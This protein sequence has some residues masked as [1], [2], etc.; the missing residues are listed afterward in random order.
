MGTSTAFVDPACSGGESDLDLQSTKDCVLLRR[1]VAGDQL[2]FAEVVRRH[3]SMVSGICHRMLH[4]SGD[5]EDAFQATFLVLAKKAKALEWQDS[6]AGWLHQTARRT[7]LNLRSKV[8]RRRHVESRVALETSDGGDRGCEDPSNALALGEV[9]ELLDA[10]VARLPYRFREVILLSHSEGLS[11]H[12]IA[13]RLSISVAAVKDRLERGRELLRSRLTSRGVTLGAATL[14]AWLLPTPA[15]AA[16]TTLVAPTVQAAATFT[17][18]QFVTGTLPTA[19]QLAQEVLQ[20]IGFG[21]L[22]SVVALL[23]T[24][25]TAGSLALGMLKDEPNR[26]SKG[27][28]GTILTVHN[29]DQTSGTPVSV[30]VVLEEFD[31]SLSLDVSAEAEVWLAYQAGQLSDL[32]EGQYVSLRLGDDHRTVNAIH[33]QGSMREA[34]IQGIDPAGKHIVVAYGDDEETAQPLELV[35]AED[36]IMRIGGLPATIEDLQPGME[37][38]LEFGLNGL[39]VNAIEA[40]AAE[41]A[42]IEGEVLRSDVELGQLFLGLEDDDDV[43]AQQAFEVNEETMITYDGAPAGLSDIRIG[44]MVRLRLAADQTAVRVIQASS[45]APNEAEEEDRE[46][47]EQEDEQE[48][49]SE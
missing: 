25:L 14:A 19:F 49:G 7:A 45:P 39:V 13:Q 33:V 46:E 44:S 9:V 35:L 22:K 18:G 27:L 4:R 41:D 11:R 37:V 16:A 8:A 10:E 1:F 17:S 23:L 43:P 20:V 15:N 21:K 40:E 32:K 3:A 36:A 28:R 48:D 38:P 30:T 26:F 12:D 6:V 5:A 29:G 47:A 34:S 42:I 24:L 31:T 2:A